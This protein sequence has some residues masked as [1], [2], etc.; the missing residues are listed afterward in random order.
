MEVQVYRDKDLEE[1][2]HSNEALDEWNKIVKELGLS[3]QKETVSNGKSPIPYP[4]MTSMHKNIISTICPRHCRV[5]EF[6]S[7]P[8]PVKVLREISLCRTEKYF[9]EVRIHYSEHDPDPFVVGIK[10]T[11]KVWDG[12][13][14]KGEEDG[15]EIKTRERAEEIA[16]NLNRKPSDISENIVKEYIIARFGP[17]KKSW[18]ELKEDARQI[19]LSDLK[20]KLMRKKDEVIK[21]IENLE[22]ATTSFLEGKISKYELERGL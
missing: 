16:K 3:G 13:H 2:I 8:I 21:S 4:V 17:E 1:L 5:E 6:N 14:Y 20:Y 19:I 12:N 7:V 11:Y 10:C 15:S 18:K 9:N 22:L